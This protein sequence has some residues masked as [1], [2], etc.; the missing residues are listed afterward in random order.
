MAKFNAKNLA[1]AVFLGVLLIGIV[2]V[3]YAQEALPKG[4]DSFETAV[5][6]EPG[7][8]Q[9]GSLKSK[10]VE[11]FYV[12]DIKPGQEINVK[13]IFAAADVNIGAEAILALYDKDGTELAG[14]EEGFYEKPASI[15]VSW[16]HTGKDLDK[17]YIKAG[18][19]LFKIDPFSLEVSLKGEG[20][21][22]MPLA[23]EGE[24]PAAKGLNWVLI[25]GIIVVIGIVVYFLLKRKR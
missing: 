7:S 16:L 6:L 14:E 24:E 1:I 21:E 12:T 8:Y 11:Y 25:L 17:Y 10:E 5:K 4:G 19:G 18:S 13:G 3:V 2:G 9:G 15:T 22:G 23:E 20:E